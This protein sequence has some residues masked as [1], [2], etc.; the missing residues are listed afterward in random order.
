[1]IAAGAL[2]IVVDQKV[3]KVN[4]WVDYH[5]GGQKTIQHMVGRDATDEVNVYVFWTV[6]SAMRGYILRRCE[7]P[8]FCF[9]A[10]ANDAIPDW[11]STRPL[12]EFHTAN[13][14]GDL[15]T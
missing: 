6:Y 5:P 15:S 8:P 12:G 4:A 14:A 7:Q 1:M 2:I 10:A 13:T 3:L 11:K 9:Y